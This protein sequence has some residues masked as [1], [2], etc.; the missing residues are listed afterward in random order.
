MFVCVCV[1]CS[2]FC[3]LI[4][5]KFLSFVQ[6]FRPENLGLVFSVVPDYSLSYKRQQH[7]MNKFHRKLTAFFHTG[8]IKQTTV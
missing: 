1:C 2:S 4:C 3:F 6:P 7:L 8:V 5:P